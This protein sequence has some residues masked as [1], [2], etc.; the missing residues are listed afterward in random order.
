[1]I[2]AGIVCAGGSDAP[3]ETSNPFQG[4]YDAIHRSAPLDDPQEC[5]T[6]TQALQLYTLNGAYAAKEE[7]RLGEIA[8]GFQAD[9]VVVKYDLL[10]SPDKLLA[11]DVLSRVFVQAL[12]PFKPPGSLA[13]MARFVCRV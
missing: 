5:L 9:F 10:A 12:L 8:P 11:P 1:M 7:T 2:K 3:I 6:F 13:K 4:M